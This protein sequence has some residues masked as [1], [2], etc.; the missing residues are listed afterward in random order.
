MGGG[1]VKRPG[2]MVYFSMRPSL[3]F[4]NDEQLGK[5]FRAMLDYAEYGTKPDFIDPLLGMAWSFVSSGIDR[6]WESYIEKVDKRKYATYCREAQKR[7]LE[8]LPFEEWR[9]LYDDERKRLLE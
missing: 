7:Q 2:V 4:L 5:L 6:D 9:V 8:E 3:N 1:K